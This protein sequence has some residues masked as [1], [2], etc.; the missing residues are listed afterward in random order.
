MKLK[1]YLTTHYFFGVMS[2]LF[3]C[4]ALLLCINFETE[5]AMLVVFNVVFSIFTIALFMITKTRL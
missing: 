4:F 5:N 3:L 2:I 1:T